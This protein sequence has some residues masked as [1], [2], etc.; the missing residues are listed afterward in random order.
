MEDPD[1]ASAQEELDRALLPRHGLRTAWGCIVVEFSA[2]D[3]TDGTVMVEVSGYLNEDPY[4]QLPH[5]RQ[6]VEEVGL[7]L[8]DV[9]NAMLESEAELSMW[10]CDLEWQDNYTTSQLF[11]LL[12]FIG[13][14][15]NV[16]FMRAG[17]QIGDW[18][19]KTDIHAILHACRDPKLLSSLDDESRLPITRSI[20]E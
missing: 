11:N 18:L 19:A 4:L 2:S 3:L 1:D 16:A 8:S 15:D 13:V 17:G 5:L 6:G 10:D 20:V 12:G 9:A 14:A 7:F